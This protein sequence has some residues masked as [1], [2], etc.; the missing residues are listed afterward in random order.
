MLRARDAT[1]SDSLLPVAK[2][3]KNLLHESVE[4]NNNSAYKNHDILSVIFPSLTIEE[5]FVCERVCS[6]WYQAMRKHKIVE[7]IFPQINE[8]R[9]LRD[10]IQ[11]KNEMK[12]FKKESPFFRG[13]ESLGHVASSVPVALFC[14]SPIA[15]PFF[16]SEGSGVPSLYLKAAAVHSLI[17]A[18]ICQSVPFNPIFTIGAIYASAVILEMTRADMRK[19]YVTSTEGQIPWK[20]CREYHKFLSLLPKSSRV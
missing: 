20:V 7:K 6:D 12:R 1:W 16:V 2:R 11:Y 14:S 3:Q 5:C 15:V 17:V 13:V 18:A 9:A 19:A 8:M 4:D 10:R